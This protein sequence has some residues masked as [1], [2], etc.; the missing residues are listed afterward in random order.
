MIKLTYLT[1]ALKRMQICGRK[2]KLET[3]EIQKLTLDIMKCSFGIQRA[4]PTQHVKHIQV[5]AAEL[6]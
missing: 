6:E 3:H 5:L 1:P 4:D 2:E